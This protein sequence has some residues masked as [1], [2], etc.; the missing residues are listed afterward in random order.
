M[1]TNVFSDETNLRR[2]ISVHA[3]Y[4]AGLFFAA[5]DSK[6]RIKYPAF[7]LIFCDKGEANLSFSSKQLTLK[8]GECAFFPPNI[9]FTASVA[10]KNVTVF[11]AVFSMK[12]NS[13]SLFSGKPIAVS[14]FGKSLLIR[15]LKF[16]PLYFKTDKYNS[17]SHLPERQEDC[18]PLTEQSIRLLLELF[19]IECIKPA[20]KS[21]ITQLSDDDTATESQKIASEIYAYL[22]EHTRDKISLADVADALYFS[23]S[24]IKKAFRKETGKTVMQVFSE[25]KIEEAKKL[26]AQG[27]PFG[28]IS[29]KLSFCN[30]NYFT[31]VFKEVSGMTPSDYK[32]SL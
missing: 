30:K 27:V 32:K 8:S 14:S 12:E 28:E 5:N 29:E 7:S 31:A 13:V 25:L 3:L 22:T 1:S 21:I 26:I 11:Y 17:I 23:E 24:Y 2:I 20:D 10:S 9:E 15:L 18:S 6:S 4:G 16:C 19:I